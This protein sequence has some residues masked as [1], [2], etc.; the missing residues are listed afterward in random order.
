MTIHR[1]PRW[2]GNV[3]RYHTWPTIQEQSVA[4]HSWN[5]VRLLLVLWPD[6]PQPVL[7][8]ALL[9][10]VGEVEAGDPPYPSKR[11]Y[12]ELKIGH[13]RAEYNVHVA[14][15]EPWLLPAPIIVDDHSRTLVKLADMMEMWEFG[16]AEVE[17]GNR[18][19]QII[20]DRCWAFMEKSVCNLEEE[21]SK[22]F[23]RYVEQRAIAHRTTM[24]GLAFKQEQEEER[25]R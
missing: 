4:S 6:A 10:D 3:R 9:H 1:D 25:R 20:V 19:G 13:D 18:H 15:S 5:V 21:E 11:D 16:I 2:G 14:M 7:V 22:R 12:P 17:L 8:A 24:G 23:H